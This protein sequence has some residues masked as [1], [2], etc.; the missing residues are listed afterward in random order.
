MVDSNILLKFIKEDIGLCSIATKNFWGYSHKS[1]VSGRL[2]R[3]LRHGLR[4]WYSSSRSTRASSSWGRRTSFSDHRML[5]ISASSSSGPHWYTVE[6]LSHCI[7]NSLCCM[8]V[9]C[10]SWGRCS[11]IC[12]SSCCSSGSGGGHDIDSPGLFLRSMVSAMQ[13]SYMDDRDECRG[14]GLVMCSPRAACCCI[15]W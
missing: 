15:N 5:R 12:G 1:D 9:W 11:G 6:G 4:R 7:S 8:G 10:G 3:G 14:F 13:L 2:D